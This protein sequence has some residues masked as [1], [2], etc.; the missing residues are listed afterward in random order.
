[1]AVREFA[2]RIIL[3]EKSS[4]EAYC[5]FLRNKGMLIGKGTRFYEP[6]S[7]SV[8]LTRP[9]M[10]SI[11]ENVQITR[12]VTI[13]THDYGWSVIKGYYGDVLGSCGEVVIGNNI[14]I[15]VGTTILKGVHIG[16][17]V[18]IGSNSLV[19]RDIPSNCVAVGSPCKPLCSL[20]E[21]TKRCQE[22]QV[23]EAYQQFRC[24]R[25]RFGVCAS[26]EE[27]REFFW[28]FCDKD[29][30]NATPAF[31]A[32]MQLVEGSRALSEHRFADVASQ[33]PFASFEDFV[34]YC[35]D[36]MVEEGLSL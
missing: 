13:L 3:R 31:A 26:K 17:N 21:Y 10:I 5:S 18:I 28:L 32:V 24:Y 29:V 16:D 35:E 1:M 12:D 36:R 9:Y 22:R 19:N 30:V 27:F 25:M 6:R 8:D 33:R 14:F 34:V 20:E 7:V 23:D 2:R 4:S 11:G 15:G